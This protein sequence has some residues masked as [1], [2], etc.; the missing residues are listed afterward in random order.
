[1]K[2]EHLILITLILLVIF[3]INKKC[4]C[5]TAENFGIIDSTRPEVDGGLMAQHIRHIRHIRHI[6]K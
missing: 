6:S 5:I 1:M 3:M 4:N 2:S